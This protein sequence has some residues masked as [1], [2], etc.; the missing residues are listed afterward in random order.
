MKLECQKCGSWVNPFGSQ[1]HKV[2]KPNGKHWFWVI[3]PTHFLNK[4]DKFLPKIEE[5]D[6]LKDT[7]VLEK[8]SEQKKVY[9]AKYHGSNIFWRLRFNYVKKRIELELLDLTSQKQ[10]TTRYHKN[11]EVIKVDWND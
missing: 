2:M 1:E 9:C 3:I 5:E 11:V 8:Q 10:I 4:W 7:L 6:L